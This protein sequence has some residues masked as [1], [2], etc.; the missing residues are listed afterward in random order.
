MFFLF[1]AG[2]NYPFYGLQWHPEKAAFE[3]HPEKDTRH[4]WN[5]VR[6]G[7][8]FANFFV[9][10]ARKNSNTF[11][12]YEDELEWVIEKYPHTFTGFNKESKTPFD[13]IYVF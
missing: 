7:Q 5:A 8:Y 4:T 12:T 2:K 11:G 3:W 6:L 1:D 13:Q 9:N 10:E